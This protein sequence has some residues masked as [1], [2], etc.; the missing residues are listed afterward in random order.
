M[1]KKAIHEL[2]VSYNN[3]TFGDTTVSIGINISRSK[4]KPN[5]ID[6]ML[7]GKRLDLKMFAGVAGGQEGQQSLVEDSDL[8]VSG[9]FDASGV[10]IKPKSFGATLSATIGTVD[11][12]VLKTFAKRSGRI[13]VYSVDDAEEKK[14]GRKKAEAE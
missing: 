11:D 1:A 13:E 10:S 9:I 4:H 14:P 12:E 7:V 8:E 5:D 6:K 3:V 2:P